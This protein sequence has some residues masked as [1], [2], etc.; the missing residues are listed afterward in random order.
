MRVSDTFIISDQENLTEDLTESLTEDLTESLS[1]DLTESLTED[2]TESLTESLTED[3]TESLSVNVNSDLGEKSL[4]DYKF[5]K[6]LGEGAFAT[7][8]KVKID[9]RIVALKIITVSYNSQEYKK[10][11]TEVKILETISSPRC[12]PFL[13]CYYDHSY[14][15]KTGQLLIE[16]EYIDGPTL[17][18]YARPLHMEKLYFHLLLILKDIITGLIVVHD[19][20]IIHNDIKPANIVIDKDL[21]PKLIDFG[22]SCFTH[23]CENTEC[24]EGFTGT[25][26]YASPEMIADM[27]RFPESDIWSLG[28]TLY[29]TATGEYP[30]N[31]K[32]MN[33]RQILRT[34]VN[35]EPVKLNTTNT[36]LNTIV[37]RSL[38]KDPRQRITASEISNLLENL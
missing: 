36:L 8:W 1:E 17:K 26:Q 6:K 25:P 19:K 20:G 4:T 12:N 7:V 30:Y 38:I 5:L 18:K 16:M 37:N 15:L 35:D 21:I 9:S 3:L 22:V 24:C 23:P 13:A 34:T 28:V 27:I 29:N 31:Y 14:D 32:D 10:A 11:I 33:R 2:L